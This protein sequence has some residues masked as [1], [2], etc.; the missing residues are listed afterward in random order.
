MKVIFQYR[1]GR[2][3]SAE[4]SLPLSDGTGFPACV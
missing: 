1:D 2:L 3:K 4:H